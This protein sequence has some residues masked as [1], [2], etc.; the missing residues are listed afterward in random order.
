VNATNHVLTDTAAV[1]RLDK[2]VGATVLVA[3]L[4][5]AVPKTPL[6]FVSQ[7]RWASR[8]ETPVR[9][10]HRVRLAFD[11]SGLPGHPN[12][13]SRRNGCVLPFPNCGPRTNYRH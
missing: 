11:T 9:K 3:L 13:A 10:A 8:K 7:L 6:R 4:L 2:A 1:R 5:A 12:T